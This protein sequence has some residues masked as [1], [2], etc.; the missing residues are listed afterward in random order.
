MAY[1]FRSDETVEQGVRRIFREQIDGAVAAIDSNASDPG[2]A[3]HETRKHCKRI[4]ALLRLV[5]PGFEEVYQRENAWFRDAA[6][7]L[8]DIRDSDVLITTADAVIERA[9]GR[10][11]PDHAEAVREE[12]RRRRSAIIKTCIDDE[13]RLERHKAMISEARIRTD[14]WPHAFGGVGAAMAGMKKT[15][16]RGR[17]GLKDSARGGG[18]E[19]YHDWRKRVKH[20]R[21]HMALLLDI[22]SAKL[23]KRW[24]ISKA[25]SDSL[26]E[27]HDLCVLRDALRADAASFGGDAAADAFSKVIEKR[28]GKL[29]K[30]SLRLGD[31]LFDEKPGKLAKSLGKRWKKW[32]HPAS[33]QKTSDPG[34]Q[35]APAPAPTG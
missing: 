16:K 9:G 17:K 31:E 18:A 12:L 32:M 29:R 14:D 15:Y 13:S 30:H 2:K 23:T 21:H 8:S 6:A 33:E 28:V 7:T 25:L 22:H 27:D 34:T 3:V 4:R 19:E 11:S 26:G 35:P 24:E 1:R 20:H 5:R 10:I